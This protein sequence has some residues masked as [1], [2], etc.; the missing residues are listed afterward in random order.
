MKIAIFNLRNLFAAGDHQIF[1]ELITYTNELVEQRIEQ[2]VAT[3]I[4]LG[5]DII[6][7][8]EIGSAEVLK[9]MADKL[10]GKYYSFMAKPESRGIAN[11]ILY[12]DA[13]ATCKSFRL[14]P[15]LP[16]FTVGAGEPY[17]GQLKSYREVI[18]FITTYA[19]KPLHVLGL[20]LKSPLA[21]PLN[22]E[23]KEAAQPTSQTETSDGIIRSSLRRLAEARA[24]RLVLDQMFNTDSTLQVI[25]TGDF[26]DTET[27]ATLRALKGESDLFPGR[28][29][30]VCERLPQAKRY[31]IVEGDYQRLI[32]HI[33]V[34]KP[35]LS[36]IL[37]VEIKNDNLQNQEAEPNSAYL[38]DSD[39]APIVV[40][41]KD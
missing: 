35:L 33:L 34:S 17:V 26:N 18:H 27:S 12:R 31:S 40:E 37:S 16:L 4:K 15:S 10:P 1:D 20:H 28:L 11:G 6:V 14:S 2:T 30:N 7:V 24:L 9:T 13:Q 22:N 32:D 23:P 8:N 29:T 38:I 3:I 41:L 19:G 25:V 5:A 21:T 36:Q 39:H